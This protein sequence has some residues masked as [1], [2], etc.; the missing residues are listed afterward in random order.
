MP[1][2]PLPLISGLTRFSERGAG[3]DAERRAALW[4][5][6][7]LRRAGR[8]ARIETFWCRPNW[9]LT[10]AWHAALGLAG[11]LTAVGSPRVGGALILVALLSVIA[12]GV[13]GVSLGRR[14]TP[15]RASQNVV[16]DAGNEASGQAQG[17]R[18]RRGRSPTPGPVHLII[19][20][21][22]D[23]GRTGLIHRAPVR[24][25]AARLRPLAGGRLPGWLGWLVI[26]LAGA[27]AIAVVRLNGDHSTIVGVLQLVPTVALVLTVALLLDQATA[28][29][30]P[31][32]GDNGSGVAA[33]VTLARALH[34]APPG[35]MHVD[36]VLQGAGDGHA[37]GLQRYLRA[38]RGQLDR[39]NT[40]VL[41]I[42]A[43]GAGDPR[44][45]IS[46][47][48]LV[49]VAHFAPL[50]RLAAA[51]AGQVPHLRAGPTR[52]RTASP[53]LPATMKRL[54]SLA[55]GALDR[56]DLPTRTHTAADTIDNVQ[57]ASVQR[58]VEL[59]LLL[60]DEVD[61]Y[62]AVAG[63]QRPVPDPQAPS[64]LTPA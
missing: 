48:Q 33:A 51:A 47:G 59:A 49:P 57:S 16:S 12:D 23:A 50:R 8:S 18:T 43:C 46:E 53:A 28:A 32:A 54:P 39:T 58:T 2:D 7:E 20:A 62:L 34:T 38:R 31:A 15:E 44:W 11:S 1:V 19:T 29:F 27:L 63:P 21:N 4:L 36:L 22:L 45:W 5:A 17:L 24:R 52:T 10:H 35:R 9:A 26:S 37:I 3:T 6:G 30:G 14:L 41:G 60:V 42:C 64:P 61:S 55:L 25:A 56:D 40:I 13:F